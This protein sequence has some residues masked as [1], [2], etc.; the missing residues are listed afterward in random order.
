M[1]DA[2]EQW[3]RRFGPLKG[4]VHGAGVIHDKLLKDKTPESFDRVIST[5]LD[6]ALTI[7]RLI[8]PDELEFAGLL[9]ERRGPVRQPG[10]GRLR[11]RQRRAQQTGDLG[12][13]AAGA[14][15]SSR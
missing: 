1:A 2:L 11:G 13:T 4:L 6:G 8:E 10:P 3:R 12:S 5:K 9:F 7:A 14:V 15:G